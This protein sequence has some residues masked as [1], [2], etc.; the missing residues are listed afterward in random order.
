MTK[1][2]TRKEALSTAIAF[3]EDA[4]CAEFE[5]TLEVL[6]KMLE[7][8]SK[9]RS[10]SDTPSKT[11]ARIANEKLIKQLYDLVDEKPFNCTFVQEHLTG[12]L[13]P[14]KAAAVMNVGID[15]GLFT[16]DK[17]GKKRIYT[18]VA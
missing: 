8:L 2:M 17:D 12:V 4:E 5:E 1:T 15:L 14:Q 7:Q 3:I 16:E 9:P 18:K 13:T 11:T 10:K 6:N